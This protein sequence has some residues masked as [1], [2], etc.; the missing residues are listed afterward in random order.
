MPRPNVLVKESIKT[1]FCLDCLRNGAA[2]GARKLGQASV[3][4]G[5][6][7]VDEVTT[8]CPLVPVN[9]KDGGVVPAQFLNLSVVFSTSESVDMRMY[10]C[11]SNVA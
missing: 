3:A 9:E 7:R 5:G 1:K 6:G 10:R 8:C 2:C 11:P 4:G